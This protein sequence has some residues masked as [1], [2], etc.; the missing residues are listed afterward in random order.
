MTPP[1]HF[2]PQ[3]K[4]MLRAVPGVGEG[5]ILRLERAGI[6]SLSELAEH[7][8]VSL[9]ARLALANCSHCWERTPKARQLAEAMTTLAR[10]ICGVASPGVPNT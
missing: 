3:E 2:A 9:T 5:M 10:Q 8:A 7:D 6:S 1:R 4:Q